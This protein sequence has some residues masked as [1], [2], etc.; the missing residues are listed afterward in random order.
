MMDQPWCNESSCRFRAEGEGITA[1]LLTV[2]S[3][4]S[5]TLE[6]VVR[7]RQ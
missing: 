4:R 6:V 1:G 3:V 5:G 2:Q 7:Y